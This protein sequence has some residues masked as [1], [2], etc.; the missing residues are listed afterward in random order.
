MRNE[1]F[2]KNMQFPKDPLDILNALRRCFSE[3]G[4]SRL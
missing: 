1:T 4:S 2:P 3:R